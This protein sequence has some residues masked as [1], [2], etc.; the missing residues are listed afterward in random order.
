MRELVNDPTVIAFAAFVVGLC[1][2]ASILDH[3]RRETR[4][5]R[6][7]AEIPEPPHGDVPYVEAP[8]DRICTAELSR[9]GSDVKLR[10]GLV[11]G[12]LPPHYD[13]LDELDFLTA[14]E[15]H[16]IPCEPYHGAAA[17]KAKGRS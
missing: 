10:C 14:N 11:Y 6:R 3:T 16:A 13:P 9:V 4:H 7:P 1:L 8:Y 12:H 5:A 15:F 2:A 17:D